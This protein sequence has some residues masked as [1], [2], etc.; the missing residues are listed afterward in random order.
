MTTDRFEP[1]VRQPWKQPFGGS[2][3]ATAFVDQT[4]SQSSE[5]M[6]KKTHVKLG[7]VG[8]EAGAGSPA[9]ILLVIP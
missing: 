9:S 8:Y 6:P 2:E 7:V 1:V 3:G 4:K 5:L